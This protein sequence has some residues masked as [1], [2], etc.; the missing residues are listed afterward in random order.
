MNKNK[1]IFRF[2]IIKSEMKNQ[3]SDIAR[4]SEL[5]VIEQENNNLHLYI[6]IYKY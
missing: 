4:T 1:F 5:A 6:H 3:V 2:F